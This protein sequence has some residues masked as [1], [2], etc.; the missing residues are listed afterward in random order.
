[1]RETNNSSGVGLWLTFIVLLGLSGFFAYHFYTANQSLKV[2]LDEISQRET[3]LI[4]ENKELKI[5]NFAN[6]NLQNVL[7]FLPLAA[8]V[9]FRNSSFDIFILDISQ[10]NLDL[11]LKD[12]NGTPLNSFHR[13][14]ETYGVEEKEL[15][16]AMNAGMYLSDY[17]AQGLYISNGE[18]EKEIDLR[19][20]EKFLNFYL[21]P[22]GV[23]FLNNTGAHVVKS[24]NYSTYEESEIHLATQS[25]PMLVYNDTIHQKFQEG[26]SNLHIRNGVGTIT[27]DIVVF[28]ISNEPVN[29]YDFASLFRDRLGCR[30][31]LYLDGAI[32]KMYLPE[33]GRKDLSGQLGPMFAI[34]E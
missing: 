8:K 10:H 32:S 15:A 24:E 1:M 4:E 11:Y 27:S 19:D 21:K 3:N 14:R 29:F 34:F 26:S 18:K 28:A 12:A 13:L 5:S 7:S 23:F 17:G 6:E 30:N 20:S 16:F 9:N 25:G 31:A 22:N 33:L 2:E